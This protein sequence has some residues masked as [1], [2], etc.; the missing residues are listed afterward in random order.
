MEGQRWNKV[1]KAVRQIL[2]SLGNDDM[3]CGIV[4]NNNCHVV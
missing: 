4:F 1:T 3:V 2:G